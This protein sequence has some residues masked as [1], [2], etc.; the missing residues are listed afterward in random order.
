M[1]WQTSTAD[2]CRTF[3]GCM[4]YILY[5]MIKIYDSDVQLLYTVQILC[6]GNFPIY[7]VVISCAPSRLLCGRSCSGGGVTWWIQ[8]AAA[9]GSGNLPQNERKLLLEGPIFSLNH[10]SGLNVTHL[11]RIL[12]FASRIFV[13]FF[14]YTQLMCVNRP[15]SFR[16][17]NLRNLCP[18][19]SQYRRS[20]DFFDTSPSVVE[21]VKLP[22]LLPNRIPNFW[23]WF[24][25][26]RLKSKKIAGAALDVFEKVPNEK[27]LGVGQSQC[28]V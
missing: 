4:M 8:A 11:G 10:D 27:H 23:N 7:D 6:C 24:Q 1:N 2:A 3:F 19:M 21:K 28:R 12:R 26:L 17:V 15:S 25:V 5:N 14:W 18:K 16:S 20:T 9:K 22:W 13:P